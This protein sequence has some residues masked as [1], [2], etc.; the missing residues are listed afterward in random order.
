MLGLMKYVLCDKDVTDIPMMTGFVKRSYACPLEYAS[1]NRSSNINRQ[2]S[3]RG[4]LKP[5]GITSL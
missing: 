5:T 1:F 4:F 3:L 2:G